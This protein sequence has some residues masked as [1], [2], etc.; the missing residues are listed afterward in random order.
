MEF[1]ECLCQIRKSKGMSQEKLA[2]I[3]G[4][5]RQAVSKWETRVYLLANKRILLLLIR[6]TT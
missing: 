1:R 6:D 2:E 4:V 5:S 3:V